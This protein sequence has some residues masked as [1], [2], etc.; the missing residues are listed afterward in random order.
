MLQEK[1]QNLIFALLTGHSIKS[2]FRSI[3]RQDIW[4]NIPMVNFFL[5]LFEIDVIAEELQRKRGRMRLK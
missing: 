1:T 2:Q 3:R 5:S 4:D